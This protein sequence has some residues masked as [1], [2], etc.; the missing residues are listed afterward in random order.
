MGGSFM[1]LDAARLLV[2]ILAS[3]LS[4]AIDNPNKIAALEKALKKK[5]PVLFHEY[6]QTL[7]EVRQNP[8]TVALPIEF[9]TLQSKLIQNR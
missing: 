6:S 8:R 3:N 4:I 2:D 9:A 5:D 7:E 1:Q